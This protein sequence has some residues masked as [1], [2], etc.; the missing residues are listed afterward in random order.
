MPLFKTIA[1]N[2]YTK[3]FVWKINE[4]FDELFRSV[5]LKDISLA[6][7]ENMK[8]ESHQRGFLSVRRLLMEA[9]YTDFD[10][11]YDEDGKPHLREA[12]RGKRKTGSGKQ[13]V[14][15]DFHLPSSISHLPSH[16]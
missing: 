5:A 9:G 7:L 10:L 15:S 2:G 11:Y 6:R 8:S 12:G 16:A 3:V 13:G 4:T 14:G 1:L